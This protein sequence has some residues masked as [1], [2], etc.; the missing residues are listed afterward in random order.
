MHFIMTMALQIKLIVKQNF[1]KLFKKQYD[2]LYI[3]KHSTR[4]QGKKKNNKFTC[5]A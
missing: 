1:Y 5:I 2:L 3:L 4:S